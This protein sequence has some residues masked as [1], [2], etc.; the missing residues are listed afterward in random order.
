MSEFVPGHL[1]VNPRT[2]DTGSCEPL[3]M[4]AWNQT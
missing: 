1:E 3:V 2:V 4:D